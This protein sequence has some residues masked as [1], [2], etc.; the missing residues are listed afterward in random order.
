M[1]HTRTTFFVLTLTAIICTTFLTGCPPQQQPPPTLPPLT[2]AQEFNL[3]NAQAAA[4]ETLRLTGDVNL[5]FTDSKGKHSYDAHGV[6]MIDK[7]PANPNLLLTG[8]YLGQEVFEM[9]MNQENYWLIDYNDKIAYVGTP[10]LADS[11]PEDIAP[12]A[13]LSPT[14]LRPQR[15]LSLLAIT[16]L[17]DNA[18]EHTVFFTGAP[19]YYG[20]NVVVIQ[21]PGDQRAWVERRLCVNA[22]DDRV[23]GVTLYTRDGFFIASSKL[24]DYRPITS[25]GESSDSTG[26]SGPQIPFLID[27]KYVAANAGLVIKVDKAWL[28][29]K[30]DPNYIFAMPNLQGLRVVDL[31]DPAN[32]PTTN[33]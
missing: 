28:S 25:D 6:L 5:T 20:T 26:V 21:M 23:Q 27:I 1:A 10:N 14:T 29:F 13:P 24:S 32:W 9:G 30:G 33:Q 22:Y 8:T 12:Q 17:V 16:P 18:T 31:D 2:A 15:I 3:L 11:L 4:I 19:P 7:R